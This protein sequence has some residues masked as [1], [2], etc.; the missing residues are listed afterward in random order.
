M[1]MNDLVCPVTYLKKVCK[2]ERGNNFRYVLKETMEPF[3]IRANENE[4]A[5]LIICKT[6]QGSYCRYM[7]K[8]RW[9]HLP[10]SLMKV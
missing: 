1:I 6:E 9:N 5:M 7:Q 2:S 8:R 3:P 10:H 4:G